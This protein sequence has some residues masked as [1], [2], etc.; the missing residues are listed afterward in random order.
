MLEATA[1]DEAEALDET[2]ADDEAD[3]ATALDEAAALDRRDETTELGMSVETATDNEAETDEETTLEE[4][5]HG[6]QAVPVGSL[7]K[8]HS[9]NGASKNCP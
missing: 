1:D 6:A 2:A 4:D 7:G 5:G 9:D 3:E 8:P